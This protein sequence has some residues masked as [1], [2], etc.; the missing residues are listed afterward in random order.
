MIEDKKIGLKV[1]EN[2]L[3][4]LW[5]RVIESTENTIKSLKNDVIINEA[6]LNMARQ[7]LSEAGDL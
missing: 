5:H 4:E 6:I 2:E 3:E 1:A 7:K